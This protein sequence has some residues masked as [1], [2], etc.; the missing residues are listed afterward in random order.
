MNFRVSNANTYRKIVPLHPHNPHIHHID[1]KFSK[2]DFPCDKILKTIQALD[3]SK[4]H[5][6]ETA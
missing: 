3:L 6:H 5:S 4:A 2:V 1:E